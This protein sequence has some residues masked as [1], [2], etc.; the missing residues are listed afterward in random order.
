MALDHVEVRLLESMRMEVTLPSG[1]VTTED[2][3]PT[4]RISIPVPGGGKPVS[5]IAHRADDVSIGADGRYN[6][7]RVQDAQNEDKFFHVITDEAGKQITVLMTEEDW[8]RYQTALSDFAG[9][10]ARNPAVFHP[11]AASAGFGLFAPQAQ[12]GD[13]GARPATPFRPIATTR[14]SAMG[15]GEDRLSSYYNSSDLDIAVY[16]PRTPAARTALLNAGY[17]EV[18]YA[19]LD[20]HEN[21]IRVPRFMTPLDAQLYQNLGAP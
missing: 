12:A 6:D 13:A 21:P 10:A 1:E 16:N 9:A 4:Y 17:V 11:T 7:P 8:G 15:I 2:L 14:M 19:T 3:L 20:E 18:Q 5:I